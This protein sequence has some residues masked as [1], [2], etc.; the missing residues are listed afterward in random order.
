MIDKLS[1]PYNKYA[2]PEAA[3]DE[4]D[5]IRLMCK[6]FPR[7]PRQK[8]ALFAC[9]A[10]LLELPG[11]IYGLSMDEFSPEEDLLP[12]SDPEALGA[13]LA[14]AVLSDVLAAGCVPEFYMH[15]VSGPPAAPEFCLALT[16]GV[17]SVLAQGRC[18]LLGGDYGQSVGPGGWRYT[19]FAMGI[20]GER[21][22]LTRV[23][24]DTS[25]DTPQALWITGT[26]GDGNAH[27]LRG[28]MPRFEPRFAEAR[29]IRGRATACTDTSG[30]LGESL[31][32]L[33]MCNPRHRLEVDGASVPFAPEARAAAAA[34]NFPESAFALGGA[35]EYELLFTAPEGAPVNCAT[36][37]GTVTAEVG[38]PGVLWN[39]SRLSELPDA[40]ACQDREEYLQR[41][42][43]AA[44]QCGN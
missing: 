42:L 13:N 4:M 20:A 5:I 31:L 23:I 30:G 18:F 7:S 14:T 25:P 33:A 44:R 41:L 38:E 34:G 24:P 21:G 15:A 37:I 16:R 28:S 32:T 11:G 26:V 43:E 39:G 1:T 40:R 6:E 22:P 27:A 12:C 3:M 8:N 19:G 2:A 36:R 29:E 9:D 17:Q 35:G 10:E